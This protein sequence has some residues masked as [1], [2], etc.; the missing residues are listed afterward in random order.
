MKAKFVLQFLLVLTFALFLGTSLTTIYGNLLIKQELSKQD[1]QLR[2]LQVLQQKLM[3]PAGNQQT[4]EQ[5]ALQNLEKELIATNQY[6]REILIST[7]WFIV[8]L[9]A[10]GFAITYRTYYQIQSSLLKPIDKITSALSG[11]LNDELQLRRLAVNRDTALYQLNETC[12]LL[13]DN[14]QREKDHHQQVFRML[15]K[16][17]VQ[18]IEICEE[19]TIAMAGS[20]EMILANN[21]AKDF[22]IGE[23]GQRFFHFLSEAIQQNH[24]E[25]DSHGLRYKIKIPPQPRNTQDCLITIIQFLP[26]GKIMPEGPQNTAKTTPHSEK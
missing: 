7:L 10:C 15:Q 3:L 23:G 11:I 12:N 18:L 5:N 8:L 21:N 22:F 17:A 20:Q 2:K 4:S 9:T 6:S 24:S 19:P 1:Q 14:W 25:F 13:L 26:A 16:T